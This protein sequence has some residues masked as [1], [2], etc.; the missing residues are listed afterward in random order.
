MGQCL[1]HCKDVVHMNSKYAYGYQNRNKYHICVI[2]NDWHFFYIDSNPP[3]RFMADHIS[4]SKN[5][6]PMCTKRS[7]VCISRLLTPTDNEVNNGSTQY[8]AITDAF[9][10]KIVK[11]ALANKTLERNKKSILQDRLSQF[12]A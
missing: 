11:A 6:W 10:S 1:Y 12:L 7:F 9:M 5:D 4:I 8:G 2:A 3:A